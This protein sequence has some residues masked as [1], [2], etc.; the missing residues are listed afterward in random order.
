MM[1]P[2]KPPVEFQPDAGAA[3]FATLNPT[4]PLATELDTVIADDRLADGE[5][6]DSTTFVI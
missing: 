5:L 4:M 1:L 3:S 2:I 6:E